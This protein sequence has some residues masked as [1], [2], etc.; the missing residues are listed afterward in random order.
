MNIPIKIGTKT[1]YIRTD[2][3]NFMFG[4]MRTTKRKGVMVEEYAPTTFYSTLP[5]LFDALLRDKIRASE[6]TTLGELQ[7]DIGVARSELKSIM[8]DA[9]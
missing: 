1:G 4:Y 3:R 2:S 9:M 6:A 5:G 8:D 7:F